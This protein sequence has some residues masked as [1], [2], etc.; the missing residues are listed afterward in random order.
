MSLHAAPLWTGLGLVAPLRARVSGGVPGAVCGVSIDTRTLEPR[1]LFFA[2][3]GD[4]TDGHEHVRKA[5]AAGAAACVVD[6]THA[7]ALAGTGP[8]LVVND[9]LAA[10]ESLGRA[11]RD[12]TRARVIAVTGSVGKTSTKEAL[13]V[14]LIPAG[15]VHASAASYNN[16]WGVPLTL[17]R[18][19]QATPF[20]VAE[21]GM[22]HAGE[23]TPL[24]AMVRP[25]VAIVT[26][27][28]PVHLEFFPSV[29]AI[30][31]AKAEIFSGLE[32]GGVAI[33]NRDSPHFE[34][35]DTAARRSPAG[36]V[37]SFGA[38]ERADARLLE[39]T[40][41]PT[42]SL[43][44]ARIVGREISFRLGAPGRHLAENALA[45]LLAAHAVGADL[46]VAS[47]ALAFFQAGKGRGERALI[48]TAEGPFTLIDES[49]NANPASMAAALA[50]AGTLLP[51]E[52]GRRVAVLGDMLELGERSAELH[53]G[54]ADD[55]AAAKFDLVL[56]AGPMMRALSDALDERGVP[57]EWRNAAAELQR[58]VLDSIRGGDVVVVKGSNGSRMAPVVDALRQHHARVL[59]TETSE[60][61]AEMQASRATA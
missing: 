25:H 44:K 18:M 4:A 5:F 53:A 39:I 36:L 46:D 38:H 23:I 60:T 8:L 52:N 17:A 32:P 19:P 30:A 10:M 21:V 12:R 15:D 34:R 35:L 29:E 41:A 9:V 56:A 16:H 22:N 50:L 58:I 40:P 33:I 37:A 27:V 6:E 61:N 55:L 49:Y 26:N 45:V 57:C 13:R 14:A 11:A 1:D 28:S 48:E 7:D 43:V 3:K 24:V 31:D 54:L 47:T 20:C 59:A 42:H 51:G 2:I